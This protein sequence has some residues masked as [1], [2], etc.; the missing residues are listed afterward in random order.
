MIQKS[1]PT[2]Y[3]K[4]TFATVWKWDGVAVPNGAGDCNIHFDGYISAQS[5]EDGMQPISSYNVAIPCGIY[6]D[7]AAIEVAVLAQQS[8]LSDG[9][10]ILPVETP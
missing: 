3:D 10:Q 8:D 9:V 1:I 2:I 6:V 4:N 7:E 5:I